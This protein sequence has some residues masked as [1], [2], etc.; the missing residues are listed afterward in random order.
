MAIFSCLGAHEEE[1]TN[2]QAR[3]GSLGG[4]V[5]VAVGVA[6]AAMALTEPRMLAADNTGVITGV[7]TSSK[8]PEAGVWVI[9]ETDDLP[10]RFRQIV[11]TDDRGRY[12]LPELP[13]GA[14]F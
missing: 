10:T 14:S 7:M 6:W 4:A 5:L 11:V 8:G 1:R 9:A 2:M 13:K 3:P 12:L